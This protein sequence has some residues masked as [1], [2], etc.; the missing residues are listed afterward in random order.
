MLEEE[1]LSLYSQTIIILGAGNSPSVPQMKTQKLLHHC[2][3][4]FYVQISVIKHG[5]INDFM[6]PSP[7]EN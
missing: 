5:A 7:L 3:S 6:W 4:K 1:Q 2:F